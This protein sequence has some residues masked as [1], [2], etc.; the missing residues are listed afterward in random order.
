MHV[1]Y[2][3]S[4]RKDLLGTKNEEAQWKNCEGMVFTSYLIPSPI[5]PWQK[6]LRESCSSWQTATEWSHLELSNSVW[7]PYKEDL[8][9]TRS[10]AIAKMTARCTQYI[11]VPWKLYVSAKSA[12]DCARISTLQ[13]YHYSAVKLDRAVTGYRWGGSRN[14][15]FMRHKFLVL[16]VKQDSIAIAK[17]TARCAQYMDA[18]KSFQSPH[19]APGYFSRNL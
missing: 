13:S 9:K 12:D 19:Y 1:G 16:T 7:S 5:T 10:H 8:L 14:I 11:R 6:R 2:S 18:L 3:N 15:P 4:T 17:K